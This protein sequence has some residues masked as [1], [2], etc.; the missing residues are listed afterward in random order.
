MPTYGYAKSCVKE[1]YN[2]LALMHRNN[3]SA[4]LKRIIRIASSSDVRIFFWISYKNFLKTY[5][6]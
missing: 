6:Y 2:T 3:S 5:G 1:S 4:F